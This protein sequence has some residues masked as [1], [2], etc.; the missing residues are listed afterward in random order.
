MQEMVLKENGRVKASGDKLC[1]EKNKTLIFS[2][3]KHSLRNRSGS[4]SRLLDLTSHQKL[5][6]LFSPFYTKTLL[7]ENVF[8]D[9]SDSQL[10]YNL[11]VLRLC[12]ITTSHAQ[13]L[14]EPMDPTL[15]RACIAEP[16]QL[17][18]VTY[19]TIVKRMKQEFGVFGLV[20]LGGFRNLNT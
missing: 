7:Q 8:F 18:S 13:E 6:T 14:E 3:T 11:A 5:S 2:A 9:G 20:C 17:L 15:G 1:M 19:S 12:F 16:W 4:E 10:S